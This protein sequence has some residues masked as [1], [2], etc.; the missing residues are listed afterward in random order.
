MSDIEIEPITRRHSAQR[1]RLYDRW[2]QYSD[3]VDEMLKTKNFDNL[4][5]TSSK[6]QALGDHFSQQTRW[7][8]HFAHTCQLHDHDI[9][10]LKDAYQPDWKQ[11]LA[12]AA[13]M[14]GHLANGI[15]NII[16]AAAGYTGAKA[17]GFQGAGS[18]V[19]GA[20]GG[21]A[22]SVGNVFHSIKQGE[23]AEL[24]NKLERTKQL[25][26]QDEHDRQLKQQQV[27]RQKDEESKREQAEREAK[28][29]VLT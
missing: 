29:A 19:G 27:N 20:L 14:I 9:G 24:S 1:Q 10:E 28:R 17:A 4:S 22:Q 11:G 8:S 2:K 26:S 15:L 23:Q 13:S 6:T 18:A 25:A 3:Q 21:G 16:P 12:I 7:Q 5:P